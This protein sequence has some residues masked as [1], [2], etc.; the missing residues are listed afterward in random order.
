MCRTLGWTF[1]TYL[2]G[3]WLATSG[4]GVRRNRKLLTTS[5]DSAF[6]SD[7]SRVIAYRLMTI[8][9]DTSKV[10]RRRNHPGGRFILQVL[11]QYRL[12]LHLAAR[13]LINGLLPVGR[14]AKERRAQHADCLF[15]GHNGKCLV[16]EIL[17]VR[18]RLTRA[19][20]RPVSGEPMRHRAR[21]A[22]ARRRPDCRRSTWRTWPSVSADVA[23]RRASSRD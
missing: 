9:A 23:T 8:A 5:S 10:T 22:D 18:G 21:T 15:R 17:K 4:N 7:R 1:R 11:A 14:Q 3:G 13:T 12:T 19:R 2:Y 20:P 6:D 16:V